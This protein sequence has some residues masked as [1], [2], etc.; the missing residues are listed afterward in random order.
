M[1]YFESPFAAYP[2]SLVLFDLDGT[3]VDSVPGLALAVDRMLVELGKETVGESVV[4][5]WVGNGAGILVKRALYNSLA[6][7]EL[8]EHE[9]Q[10]KASELFLKHYTDA[11]C[12]GVVLYPGVRSFLQALHERKIDMAVVTNKPEH[13]VAP[14]LEHLDINHYFSLTVGGD[15]L[16]HAKPHPEPLLYALKERDVVAIR[17]LMIGDSKNDIEAA[18]NAFIPVAAVTYGYNHGE[19]IEDS[20]P[21][22]VVDS[23]MELL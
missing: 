2:P 22:W 6:V 20:Q 14:L 5:T 19:S 9:L 17:A 11:L 23:M 13:F 7:N 12:D 4:R 16:K 15:T 3:L 8:E 10:A 1:S 21:D 18:R